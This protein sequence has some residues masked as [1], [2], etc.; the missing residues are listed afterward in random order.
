MRPKLQER[1]ELEL[2]G[3]IITKA[4]PRRTQ[5]ADLWDDSVTFPPRHVGIMII[6][7]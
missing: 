3:R 6:H 5:G 7:G 2:A 4:K 1:R